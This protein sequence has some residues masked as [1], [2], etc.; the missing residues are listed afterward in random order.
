ME[1][2]LVTEVGGGG[3]GAMQVP[4]DTSKNSTSPP[5]LVKD[6]RALMSLK[7][8]KK[9]KGTSPLLSCQLARKRLN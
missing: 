3:G 6:E 9:K 4:N 1:K 7:S 2:N 8:G 5:Y